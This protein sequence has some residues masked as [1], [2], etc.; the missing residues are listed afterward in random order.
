MYYKRDRMSLRRERLVKTLQV[1]L[2]SKQARHLEM[3]ARER[4][5]SIGVIVR[6][7]VRESQADEQ[8]QAIESREGA[9]RAA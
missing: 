7:M 4:G 1:R 6:E 9:A 8:A 5:V 2:S 3:R